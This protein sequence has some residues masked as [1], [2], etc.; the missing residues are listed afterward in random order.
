MGWAGPRN[1]PW[2]PRFV[3]HRA[4]TNRRH[5]SGRYRGAETN[6]VRNIDC[7]GVSWMNPII[8]DFMRA[9]HEDHMKP[10]G[11]T[12]RRFV[13]SRA[14]EG[15]VE[16]VRLKG[17]PWNDPERPWR[18]AVDFGIEFDGLSVEDAEF[19]NTHAFAGLEEI[20]A[21]ASGDYALRHRLSGDL[22]SRLMD[23]L[24][25]GR[26][27]VRVADVRALR[28]E[29]AA[30]IAMASAAVRLARDR[31]RRACEN[32]DYCD[33]R[34]AIVRAVAVRPADDVH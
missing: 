2:G 29:L 27:A 19:P 12:K 11:Y 10:H 5:V 17:S 7:P 26:Q 16:R 14:M 25:P 34:L 21:D 13:Y 3:G 8:T 22:A 20:V 30:H 9:L 15:Y 33:R 28:Q 6:D 24:D 18:F 4:Q 1:A 32:G 31:I 23:R